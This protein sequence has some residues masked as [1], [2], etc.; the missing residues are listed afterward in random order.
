MRQSGGR[1]HNEK[2]GTKDTI[3]G[4]RA[5]VMVGGGDAVGGKPNNQIEAMTAVIGTVS[6]A[7][8]GG[9]AR[10]KGKM[11]RWRTMQGNQAAEVAT[12]GGGDDMRRSGGG[13][14]NKMGGQMTQGNWAVDDT[15]R[16]ERQTQRTQC[17]GGQHD[18]KGVRQCKAQWPPPVYDRYNIR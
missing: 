13:G 3:Q 4:N 2:R 5:M 14:R 7:I 10:A 6:V 15:K 17:S 16:G 1:Q 11:S 8:E 12:G 9:E 18:K